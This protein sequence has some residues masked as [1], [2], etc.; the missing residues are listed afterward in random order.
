MSVENASTFIVYMSTQFFEILYR[1]S[2]I[3]LRRS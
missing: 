2:S 1:L 3:R